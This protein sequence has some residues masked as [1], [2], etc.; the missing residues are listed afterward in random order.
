MRGILHGG[1]LSIQEIKAEIATMPLEERRE[2]AAYL[3]SLRHQDLA[4]Y[5]A[6]MTRKIDDENPGQWLTLEELD[7]RLG[8]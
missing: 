7:L 2:L 1:F 6:R 5:R 8:S 3:V 4:G